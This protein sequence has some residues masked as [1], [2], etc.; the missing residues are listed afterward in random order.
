MAG[1]E[2]LIVAHGSPSAPGPQ[3]EAMARLAERVAAWLP[4]WLVRGATLAAPGSLDRAL[5]GMSRPLVY[6]FFMADGYFASE[7][8]PKRL[9]KSRGPVTVLPPFGSDPALQRLMIAHVSEAAVSLHLRAEET[10][11]LLAA[12]GSQVSPASR[13]ATTALL[14]TLADTLPFKAVVAGYL[15]EAPHLADV[16]RGL[17][18][19]ICLPLFTLR[20]GHAESDV[21]EALRHAG[22]AG[23]LLPPIGTHP[24]I[25]ALIART[26]AA[27]AERRAA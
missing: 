17:G 23:E 26:L 13:L 20:A 15:E 25:P 1:N 27:Q 21:P 2:A 14:H 3:D 24:G 10:T 8:L 12:H 18:P 19:A 16:A 4:G 9:A 11:L 22:F 5:E 7:V 6:P